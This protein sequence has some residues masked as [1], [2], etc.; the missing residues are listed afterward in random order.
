MRS[1]CVDGARGSTESGAK[2]GAAKLSTRGLQRAR[3]EAQAHPASRCEVR[4]AASRVD[5]EQGSRPR[6][7]GCEVWLGD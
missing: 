6:D 2:A 7:G 4:A 5:G 1:G 3:P